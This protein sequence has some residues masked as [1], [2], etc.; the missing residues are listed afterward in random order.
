MVAVSS[1]G[2]ARTPFWPIAE[3]IGRSCE[4]LQESGLAVRRE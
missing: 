2:S 4:S 1:G 3:K